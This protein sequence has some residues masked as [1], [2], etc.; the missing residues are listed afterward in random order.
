MC[1]TVFPHIRSSPPLSLSLSSS[2]S[3]SFHAHHMTSA[4]VIDSRVHR[5]KWILCF[6]SIPIILSWSFPSESLP[7]II[8]PSLSRHMRETRD[9][10]LSESGLFCL[11]WWSLGSPI[12]LQTML[13]FLKTNW[14]PIVLFTRY[15]WVGIQASVIS[16]L[17]WINTDVRC[18]CGLL[19]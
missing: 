7:S 14:N 11:L 5:G 18:L 19:T 9:I 3:F 17:L 10:S 2:S 12:S 4:R 6:S 15:L 16:R 1:I 13:H 8:S